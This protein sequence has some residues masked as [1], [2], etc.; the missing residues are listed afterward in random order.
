M[1]RSN[2]TDDPRAFW[3]EDARPAASEPRPS[4]TLTADRMR[5]RFRWQKVHTP[6]VWA[7]KEVGDELIGYYG[8][9]TL[10]TGSF[11]Q[12]EVVIV[13]VP[14]RGSYVV[15]GTS[16]IQLIDSSMIAVGHPVRIVWLGLKKLDEARTMKLFDLHVAEGDPLDA[17]DLPSVRS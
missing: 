17:D 8:G 16:L 10:R 13:H 9:R 6:R 1:S 3:N 15:S 4:E 2:R 14:Q 5:E 7:P 11:G 12:Y